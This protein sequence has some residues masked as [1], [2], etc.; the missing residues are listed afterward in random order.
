MNI[1]MLS[2]LIILMESLL[3]KWTRMNAFQKML[4]KNLSFD[5]LDIRLSSDITITSENTT[6]NP[7]RIKQNITHSLFK[8]YK[9]CH[10]ILSQC[11]CSLRLETFSRQRMLCARIFSHAR[12]FSSLSVI[13]EDHQCF[14]YRQ[15][16]RFLSQCCDKEKT[17]TREEF[18]V[19]RCCCCFQN[20]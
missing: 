1:F 3:V 4:W 20:A 13:I 10:S 15:W 2:L 6:G 9:L 5:R 17:T 14:P 11:V 18:P 12:R 8:I 16:A 7:N 19:N